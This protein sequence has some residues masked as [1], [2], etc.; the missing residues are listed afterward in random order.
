MKL[1][2]HTSA[3]ISRW[4]FAH[5][6]RQGKADT[7]ASRLIC[8]FGPHA[9][10]IV[11]ASPARQWRVSPHIYFKFLQD[12][13]P[14]VSS[15]YG[16]PDYQLKGAIKRFVV[17]YSQPFTAPATGFSDYSARSPTAAVTRPTT[18]P[19]VAVLAKRRMVRTAR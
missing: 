5:G 14:D 3:P 8:E 6:F 17:R 19:S 2:R 1:C 9:A 10:G 12:L 16:R 18:E 13:D 4:A 7:N 11:T 15:Y